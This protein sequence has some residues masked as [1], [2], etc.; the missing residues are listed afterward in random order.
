MVAEAAQPC[1]PQ[2]RTRSSRSVCRGLALAVSREGGGL[3]GT[4]E[5]S[6]LC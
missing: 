3:S 1:T 6:A 5:D 2:A 4:R